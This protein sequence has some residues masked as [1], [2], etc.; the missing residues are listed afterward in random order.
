MRDGDAGAALLAAR[1]S[2]LL[3]GSLAPTDGE[4]AWQDSLDLLAVASGMKP[5]AL[6]GCGYETGAWLAS[7]AELARGCGLAVRRGGM[8]WLVEEELAGLPGWYAGPLHRSWAG[9]DMLAVSEPGSAA[10][11]GDAPVMLTG[12]AEAELL[13]YPVCC[14]AEHHARRRRLHELMIELIAARCES[15]TERRRF[16]ASE[17][18]PPLRDNSDRNRLLEALRSEPLAYAGFEPC[19]V[20]AALGPRGRA[21]KR[22][23]AMLE[24]AGT[25]GFSFAAGS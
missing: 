20:C 4:S 21:G 3:S 8:P 18:P 17:L 23:L 11:F 6:V 16:A 1:L 19:T 22:A 7:V 14:V 15:E 9:A 25:S 24:L 12:E 10:R 5:V 2:A 13:S